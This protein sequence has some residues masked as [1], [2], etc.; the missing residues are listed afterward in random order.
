M[1]LYRE[2]RPLTFD[3]VV[4]QEHIVGPLKQ[5]VISGDI[6][7]AYLFT[8]TRGTGKTTMAKILARAVNCLQPQAGNPCNTC[9]ICRGIL[10]GTLL[11]VAEID[12]A[13]NNSVDNI[14]QITEEIVFLP[15][16]AKYKVYIIDE[17][18]MLSSGAF[19]ALLK[20]LEEPP[21]HVIFILATTEPQ[22]IPATILSRC[23]RFDFRRITL[24]GLSRR[25]RQIAQQEQIKIDDDAVHEIAL[26]ADGA[27]RDAISL[28]DQAKTSFPEGATGADILSMTGQVS[29]SFLAELAEHLCQGEAMAVL[30]QVDQ[31]LAQGQDMVRFAHNL[32]AFYRDLLVCAVVR[33][34]RKPSET[35]LTE[36]VHANSEDLARMQ[37]VAARYRQ[38]DLIRYIRQ[39]AELLSDLRWSTNPRTL[40]ELSLLKLMAPTAAEPA[41][42][43][44]SAAAA[45]GAAGSRNQPVTANPS[46]AA[47]LQREATA[48]APPDRTDGLAG[49][50]A[51]AVLETD[52]G[53]VPIAELKPAAANARPLTEHLPPLP[54]PGPQAGVASAA[55]PGSASAAPA[56]A[57]APLSP[58]LAREAA[59]RAKEGQDRWPEILERL[60]QQ[61]MFS[62]LFARRAQVE[63]E[64][65][66]LVLYF[67]KQEKANYNVFTTSRGQEPLLRA[68]RETLGH[69]LRL[70]FR[71]REQAGPR[72]DSERSE[73]EAGL[74]W[75]NRLT[76]AAQALGIPV[77]RSEAEPEEEQ[78]S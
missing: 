54:Q 14:R 44:L 76:Q 67:A 55:A 24:G 32:A 38:E 47:A 50:V 29:R 49:A 73:T 25:L 65:D 66:L 4:E 62:Y 5:A 69:P 56:P 78:K 74:A 8:G 64:A 3:Q 39:L 53:P 7:H 19:N 12:A 60:R 13:S 34:S 71:V 27:M 48:P 40:L 11:D 9:E 45:A 17:V 23:Q 70:A 75:L 72:P 59:Q 18:H 42:V 46:S 52:P 77:D 20:T 16:K 31:L 15:T 6:A 33:D 2:W 28:L 63:A 26:L 22:R 57:A 36:L 58:D 41:G 30:Q 51:A 43:Q 37:T 68:V 10:D 21:A 61:D 1:A 35:T